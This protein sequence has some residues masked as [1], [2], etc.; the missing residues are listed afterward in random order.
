MSSSE[1]GLN[2][3]TWNCQGVLNPCFRKALLD[4]LNINSPEMLILT[5]TRLGGS[6]AAGVI[7][8]GS[9]LGILMTFYHVMRNGGE[10]AF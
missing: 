5:E 2:I 6:R 9:C 7:C 3:L 4:I 8:L 10:Q 1:I